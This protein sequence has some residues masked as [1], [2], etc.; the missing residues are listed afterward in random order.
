MRVAESAIE[1]IHS[2]ILA[3]IADA[4]TSGGASYEDGGGGV[5]KV[6]IGHGET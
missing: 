6:G 4:A 2:S 3:C 5:D 1:K